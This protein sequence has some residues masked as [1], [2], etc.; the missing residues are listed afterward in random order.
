MQEFRLLTTDFDAEFRR[1]PGGVVNVIT[2]SGSNLVHGMAYDYL[3]NTVLNARNYF[4]SG[5]SPLVYNVFGGGVGGPILRNKAFFYGT[6][7]GTRISS[8]TIITSS[9]LVVPTQAGRIGD[10]SADSAKVKA[11]LMHLTTCGNPYIV[12][13]IALDPVVQRM[14]ALVRVGAVVCVCRQTGMECSAIPS[15]LSP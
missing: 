11:S 5:V 9:S 4:T 6:Y 10:F 13:P 14:L 15:I 7:D 8:R 2:R 1:Y 3:R 12:C